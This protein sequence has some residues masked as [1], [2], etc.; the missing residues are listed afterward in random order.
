MTVTAERLS[1]SPRQT[2]HT[3]Y[4]DFVY[5]P[6]GPF[7]YGPEVCYERLE[8]CPPPKPRQTMELD[9]FWLARRPVTTRQWRDFLEETGYD[10][11]GRW[12]RTVRGWRGL[13]LRA[14]APADN[15]PQGHDAFPIVDVTHADARAYC[16][17]LSSQLGARCT[18]PGEYQWEKAARGSEGRTYPWGETV[19]RPELQWQK[20]FPVGLETY[21]FSLFV[22][23]RREW[24]R[25][26]WY[27]RNG[28]PLPVGA[29]PQNVSPYG[30]LDMSGNVWE[31]T[32][33]LYNPDVPDYHVVKGGSWGY[34]IHHTKCCVR[35][36][37]S[38]TIPSR[39]YRAQGTGFRVA[40][41]P[42][43]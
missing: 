21:L 39:E 27:W 4:G 22:A 16:D 3:R 34:S 32:S 12:Y 17:W 35:S 37:C 1:E 31:W 14:Y 28:A 18:L 2:R 8:L 23:P 43:N 40:I 20:P 38:I 33:S 5:V 30:C 25:A 36:A 13:F 15:Y 29:R 7:I 19:P 10:W 24:A 26:G 41:V 42:E 6:P 11:Q 9:A